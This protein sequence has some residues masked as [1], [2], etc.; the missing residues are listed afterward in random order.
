MTTSGICTA[1]A[2]ALSLW[3]AALSAQD[4]HG[5]ASRG[6]SAA[7]AA[8][9]AS[10]GGLA[11]ATD[12]QRR[13][14]LHVAALAGRRS[15]ALMLLDRGAQIDAR[16]AQDLTPLLMAVNRGNLE[17]AQLLL[18]RGADANAQSARF[19]VSPLGMAIMRE[20]QSTSAD[21]VRALTS[22]G[23]RLEP[24]G[25]V[26]GAPWLYLATT[27]PNL[28]LIRLLLDLGADPN[29][30]G[31]RGITPLWNAASRGNLDAV[32]LL[33]DRGAGVDGRGRDGTP[34]I[35]VAAER[36]HAAVVRALL[37][38][39]ANGG[40][41]DSATGRNLLH[42]AALVG[43][44]DI[45]EALAAARVPLSAADSAGRTPL[46]Y[47]RRY[48]HQRVADYLVG[49][50]AR[51]SR[52]AA[53]YALR[54][55]PRAGLR[56]GEAAAWYLAGRG[57]AVRTR[58][59]ILVFDADEFGIRR[60]TEPSLAN[61]F[62]TPGQVRDLD[63]VSLATTYHGDPGE[64][65]YVHTLEDSVP[66]IAFVHNPREPW[67]GSERV[68]YATPLR[69]TAV[70]GVRVTP[71]DATVEEMPA[72]AY[73]TEGDGVTAFYM[74][75]HA[76]DLDAFRR[77]VDSLVARGKRVDVAFLPILE[78]EEDSGDVRY[79]VERLAPRAVALLDPNRRT[80]LFAGMAAKVRAWR[81]GTEVFAAENPGDRFVVGRR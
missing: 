2:L 54:P 27:R 12:A 41:A 9:L 36:G 76:G 67:R 53:S 78:P 1:A 20:S 49:R 24:N 7:V 45:V 80:A 38:R 73:L 51:A 60:P 77:Q 42:T 64:R 39:G 21:L 62:L 3:G 25:E 59:H 4:I 75:F 28:D 19:G 50:G 22:G 70:L 37:E 8:L 31:T 5:A 26:R 63:V 29:R 72:L 10:D 32:L 61:G 57:W 48:G 46:D 58:S 6:D 66:R 55:L 74:G 18:S 52:G 23:A 79:V 47:A 44:L 43:H 15:I 40:F 69:D 17:V 11:N 35:R 56:E 71:L 68:V 34:A 14:P 16:D 30:G 13:T 81:P 65:A 33:L